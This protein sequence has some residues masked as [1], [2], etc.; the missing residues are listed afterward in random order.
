MNYTKGE[1]KINKTE[2][3]IGD[4]YTVKSGLTLVALVPG[5]DT[6]PEAEA[7]AHLIAA[8]PEMYEALKAVYEDENFG[9][10]S[11]KTKAIT[12]NALSKAEGK[13]NG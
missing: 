10:L 2:W 4:A 7:N 8:A 9:K 3:I 12:F 13:Y 6:L 5:I 1:W 11:P